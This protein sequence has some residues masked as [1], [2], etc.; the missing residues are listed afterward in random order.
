MTMGMFEPNPNAPRI[1]QPNP[2]AAKTPAIAHQPMPANGVTSVG[3]QSVMSASDWH[4]DGIGDHG[5]V[6]D[7]NP[8]GEF[9]RAGLVDQNIA[10][11]AGA[12][13]VGILSG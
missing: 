8:L 5:G 4:D 9:E 12:Q 2:C 10:I 7:A 1:K 13:H 11:F 3:S 6:V